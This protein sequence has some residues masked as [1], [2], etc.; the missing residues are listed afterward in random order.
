MYISTSGLAVFGV[1]VSFLSLSLYLTARRFLDKLLL[2]LLA[3]FLGFVTLYIAIDL[4]E[5]SEC[6]PG[7]KILVGYINHTLPILSP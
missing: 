3:T 1:G 2:R 4:C 7:G 5:L 6:C